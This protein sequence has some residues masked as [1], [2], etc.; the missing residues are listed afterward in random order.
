MIL[1]F[2]R[3]YECSYQLTAPLPAELTAHRAPP[4]SLIVATTHHPPPPSRLDGRLSVS[5]TVA[6]YN[7][8]PL[9]T[10]N[11]GNKLTKKRAQQTIQPNPTTRHYTPYSSTSIVR[12][13]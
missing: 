10:L 7:G 4:N 13:R 12:S 5:E 3:K 9:P 1:W 6:V 11:R 2:E 8:I